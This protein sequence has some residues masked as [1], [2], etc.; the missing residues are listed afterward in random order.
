MTFRLVSL[1]LVA[2]RVNFSL[3]GTLG[4]NFNATSDR[5][6]VMVATMGSDIGQTKIRKID[7]GGINASV[8]QM[9]A[10]ES[11]FSGYF[12]EGRKPIRLIATNLTLRYLFY[13][14]VYYC[15]RVQ[16]ISL[17]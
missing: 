12:W 10:N 5:Y 9:Y 13:Y 15:L 1:D 7:K 4:F 6:L 14:K 3:S 16:L 2:R 8:F 17:G 11:S